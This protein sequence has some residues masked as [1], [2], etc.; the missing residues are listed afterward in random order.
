MLQPM[1]P[2]RDA[3]RRLS[4]AEDGLKSFGQAVD[5]LDQPETLFPGGCRGSGFLVSWRQSLH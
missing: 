4:K 5:L 3:N 1:P 2:K